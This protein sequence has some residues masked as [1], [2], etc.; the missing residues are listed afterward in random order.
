MVD[1][2]TAQIGYFLAFKKGAPANAHPSARVLATSVTWTPRIVQR[3]DALRGGI[4]CSKAPQGAGR[5]PSLALRR[6]STAP[7]APDRGRSRAAGTSRGDR[8]GG[9]GGP[10]GQPRTSALP[11]PDGPVEGSHPVIQDPD[12]TADPRFG[13]IGARWEGVYPRCDKAGPE[14][15][16]SGAAGH[17]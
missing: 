10:G 4:R 16:S 6:G 15:G 2:G 14:G 3:E 12:L 7:V 9:A 17:D 1:R 5:V 11:V 13:R 8:L